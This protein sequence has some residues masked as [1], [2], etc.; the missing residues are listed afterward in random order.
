MSE[1]GWGG[2]MGFMRLGSLTNE[3]ATSLPRC[4]RREKLRVTVIA[5]GAKQLCVF[6]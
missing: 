5:S 6:A 3:K 1:L 4:D 2:F